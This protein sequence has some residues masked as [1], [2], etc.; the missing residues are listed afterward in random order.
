[1]LQLR[2]GTCRIPMKFYKLKG[3]E[4]YQVLKKKLTDDTVINST[5]SNN[6]MLCFRFA[7]A[8]FI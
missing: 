1:M 6:T 8:A 2:Y 7:T 5:T 4:K 3:T